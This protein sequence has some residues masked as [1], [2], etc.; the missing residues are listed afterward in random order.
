MEVRMCNAYRL[1]TNARHEISGGSLHD[2]RQ[3]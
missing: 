2:G 1:L 3:A